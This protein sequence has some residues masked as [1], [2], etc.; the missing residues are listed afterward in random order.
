VPRRDRRVESY[1]LVADPGRLTAPPP[2]PTRN[3]CA[4]APAAGGVF[5]PHLPGER[6]GPRPRSA[7]SQPSR[8]PGRLPPCWLW[9]WA[10]CSCSSRRTRGSGCAAEHHAP[11]GNGRLRTP[12]ATTTPTQLGWTAPVTAPRSSCWTRC[13]HG[14]PSTDVPGTDSVHRPACCADAS[15]QRPGLPPRGGGRR[16]RGR[17]LASATS[18]RDSPMAG[19][20]VRVPVVRSRGLEL[21][22]RPRYGEA[23]PPLESLGR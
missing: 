6:P 5:R 1:R 4:L 12:T 21:L 8:H 11:R 10:P 13:G 3:G 16:R 14:A 19:L 20:S 9:P 17:R 2:S 18:S 15:P 7:Q 22:M 23:G